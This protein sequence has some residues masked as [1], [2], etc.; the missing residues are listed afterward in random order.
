MTRAEINVLNRTWLRRLVNLENT[1]ERILRTA[2]RNMA[3]ELPLERLEDM[4]PSTLVT[5]FLDTTQNKRCHFS[6][7]APHRSDTRGRGNQGVSKP[8][9]F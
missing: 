6:D 5:L 4:P 9:R 3:L 2:F 7:M 8:I 1:N